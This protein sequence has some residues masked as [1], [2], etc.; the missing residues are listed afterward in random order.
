MTEESVREL[1][2]GVYRIHWKKSAGG[3]SSIGAVGQ[4]YSGKRWLACTN[5][6]NGHDD[7]PV[8]GYKIWDRVKKVELITVQ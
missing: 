3:G 6:T 1:P 4:T 2:F 7:A 8:Q 5:W